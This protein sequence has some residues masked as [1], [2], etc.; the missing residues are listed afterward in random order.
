MAIIAAAAALLIALGLTL[1][2]TLGPHVWPIFLPP[3]LLLVILLLTAQ[4][5]VTA[6]PRGLVVRSAVGWPRLH[7]PAAAVLETHMP[8]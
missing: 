2:L 3:L 6:G 8:R 5:V 7:L 4:I 1:L